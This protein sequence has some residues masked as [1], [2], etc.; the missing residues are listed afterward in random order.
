MSSECRRW[1]EL[2]D[3]EAAGEVLSDEARAFQE[4]HVAGCAECEREAAIWRSTRPSASEAPP[5]AR[6]L[7]AVLRDVADRGQ[8]ERFH[9]R[10]RLA[11]FALTASAFACAAAVVLWLRAVPK[12][13]PIVRGDG[14]ARVAPANPST[15]SASCSQPVA[16]VTVCLAADTE[17]TRRVLDAPDR[18]LELGRGRAVVSLSPQPT[19]TSFSIGT[20]AG[21]VTAVGTIF[22]VEIG[23][24]GVSV[25]RVIH[26]RVLVRTKTGGV[27]HPLRAG[28]TL[29][30]GENEPAP[31]SAADRARDMELLAVSGEGEPQDRKEA[32]SAPPS[33]SRA[34]HPSQ[35]EML[36]QARA[37][38]ARQE[39]AAAADLYR[40]IHAA[41]PQSP[42]GL[43]ALVS[44][45]ELLLSSL[46]DAQGALDAFDAYLARGGALAQE[47]AFG[48][49]RALRALNR[50]EQERQ[51]IERFLATYGDAPQS[52][53][54]RRRLEAL[55][56]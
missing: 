39:F 50:P 31:L 44:L 34:S 2:S 9:A 46:N 18:V 38:R 33:A 43:A 11:A 48:K 29:R 25:A 27:A 54:L 19:G 7:D 1:I 49:A 13:T 5:E 20:A 55:A 3:L 42:S 15:S 12:P 30:I 24:D 28:E 32:S 14:P 10:R 53:V 22:S 6:E 8:R 52:R 23:A 47:A 40:K 21:K 26:G 4:A 16:G 37:M 51:A 17:I 36:E 35:Q 56:R 45:G 41:N